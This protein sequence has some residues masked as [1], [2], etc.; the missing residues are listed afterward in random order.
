MATKKE[1]EKEAKQQNTLD[2]LAKAYQTVQQRENMLMSMQAWNNMMGTNYSDPIQWI[3]SQD[4]DWM[5][6][7]N[8]EQ[9]RQVYMGE[10]QTAAWR[11]RNIINRS[12]L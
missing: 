9:M 5:K 3:Y 8:D 10:L 7:R 12:Q 11:L 4:A 6:Y 2:L 1:K